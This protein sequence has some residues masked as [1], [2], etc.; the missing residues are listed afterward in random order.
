MPKKKKKYLFLVL[1]ILVVIAAVGYYMY[2]KPPVNV[3]D[4]DATKIVA[5]DLYQAFIKDSATA[6]K[7]YTNKILEVSGI[8]KQKTQNQQKQPLILL[9]AKVEGAAINCTLEGPVGE[10]SPG[11][12]LSLKG[13]CNGMGEGDADLGIAGD[14]YLVR[15]YV[16]K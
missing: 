15:C 2:N 5:G 9:D 12:P 4:A 14:V 8:V 6:K 7:E 13:I 16:V 10:V 11:Q 3:K 1:A